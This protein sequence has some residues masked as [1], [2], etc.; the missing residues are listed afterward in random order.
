MA[1]FLLHVLVFACGGCVGFMAA[2]FF[3]VGA[4]ADARDDFDGGFRIN[5]HPPVRTKI[6][7][8]SIDEGQS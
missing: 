4:R 1:D 5:N 7:H 8:G 3:I 2:A 6:W